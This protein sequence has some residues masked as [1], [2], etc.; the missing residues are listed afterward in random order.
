MI[1]CALIPGD[2]SDKIWK[3]NLCA[4]QGSWG[5]DGGGLK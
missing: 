2:E 4:W 1:K 5:Y 3:N